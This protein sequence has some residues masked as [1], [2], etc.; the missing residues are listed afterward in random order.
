MSQFDTR[1]IELVRANPKL[2]ERE[3]RNAPYEAHKKRHPEI[4]SSIATSLNSEGKKLINCIN[5][6]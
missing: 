1:L 3:L 4:W 2:Y 5:I 6:P